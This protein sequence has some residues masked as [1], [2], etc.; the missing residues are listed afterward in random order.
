VDAEHTLS[1]YFTMCP[2]FNRIQAVDARYNNYEEI[3]KARVVAPVLTIC[4]LNL[5]WRTPDETDRL[6]TANSY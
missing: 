2:I 1:H 5:S 3:A 4:D 6:I